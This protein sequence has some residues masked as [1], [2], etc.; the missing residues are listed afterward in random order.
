[1]IYSKRK[2]V[3]FAIKMMELLSNAAKII[4]SIFSM[5]NVPEEENCI[6]CQEL[7][8]VKTKKYS[9]RCTLLL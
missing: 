9:V 4:A 6:L 3:K 5:Q 8:V 1:M 7:M 2:I